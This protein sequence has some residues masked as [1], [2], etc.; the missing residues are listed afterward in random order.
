MPPALKNSFYFYPTTSSELSEEILAL[1]EKT[2][3]DLPVKLIKLA[4]MPISNNLSQIFN[5]SFSNGVY[6]EL[7]KYL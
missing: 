1:S 3:S 2:S 7:L 4:A 6:P 5:Q